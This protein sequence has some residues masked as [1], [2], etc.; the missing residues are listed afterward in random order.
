MSEGRDCTLHIRAHA[1]RINE[2]DLRN[3]HIPNPPT[4]RK[5]M[6]LSLHKHRCAL[7]LQP[8][9]Y[10]CPCGIALKAKNNIIITHD[11]ISFPADTHGQFNAP[12][13]SMADQFPA[14]T[15]LFR[16][17]LL[18]PPPPTNTTTDFVKNDKNNE[19]DEFQALP[20]NRFDEANHSINQSNEQSTDKNRINQSINWS[21][22]YMGRSGV[23]SMLTK[24]IRVPLSLN[25]VSFPLFPTAPGTSQNGKLL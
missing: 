17:P 7:K 1:T 9:Y 14:K 3:A 22:A 10:M 21:S 23:S 8:P 15:I 12:W 2:I 19:P 25:A 24:P 5:N 18:L 16:Y 6:T 13:S 20:A 11:Y 4:L